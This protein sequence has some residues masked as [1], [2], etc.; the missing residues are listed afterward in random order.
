MPRA[1]IVGL[2]IFLAVLRKQLPLLE[3]DGPATAAYQRV[4]LLGRV[5][6]GGLGLVVVLILYLMVFKP[7]T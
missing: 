6:G 2:V 1:G 4:S 5:L 3:A 7:G